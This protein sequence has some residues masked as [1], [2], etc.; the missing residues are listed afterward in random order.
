M[1]G[2]S[3]KKPRGKGKPFEPGKSGNPVGRPKV[4]PAIKEMLKG[5]T[6]DAVNLMI[7]TMNDPEQKI[8]LRINIAQDITNR[9]LGKA[10]QPIDA[11]MDATVRFVL[12]GSLKDYAE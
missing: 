1:A 8:D 4:D 9:V 12:E 7:K 3:E 11:D 2:N 5:A 10:T 6:P